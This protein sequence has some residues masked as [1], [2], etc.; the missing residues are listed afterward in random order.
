MA[1]APARD[2]NLGVIESAHPVSPSQA[3]ISLQCGQY[4]RGDVYAF[5]KGIAP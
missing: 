3:F 4:L 2:K 5:I 1:P